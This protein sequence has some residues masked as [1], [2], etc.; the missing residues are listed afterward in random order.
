MPNEQ[1]ATLQ[2]ETQ[3]EDN[4]IIVVAHINEKILSL[5]DSVKAN[6]LLQNNKEVF[7]K[8][9]RT[10]EIYEG[11]L[12]RHQ[13][14]STNKR[15]NRGGIVIDRDSKNTTQDIASLTFK[16][17]K[18]IRQERRRFSPTKTS[19]VT[20]PGRTS[21]GVKNVLDINNPTEDDI[22]E[23]KLISV[24]EEIELF[25]SQGVRTFLFKDFLKEKEGLAKISYS[26][27]FKARTQFDDYLD[28]ITNKLKK[29]ILFL[30]GYYN[31]IAL[32]D[33]YDYKANK[34][35]D[36]FKIETLNSVGIKQKGKIIDT[37]H[38]TVKSSDF[39]SAAISFYNANILLHESDR[40]NFK[41]E[42]TI[43]ALLPT[44][45]TSPDSI[46]SVIR[47]FKDLQTIL[48]RT[49]YE[50]KKSSTN[51]YKKSS[52]SAR[53]NQANTYIVQ[54]KEVFN[55]EASRLGY[56]VF[57]NKQK[58]VVVFSQEQYKN[59]QGAEAVYG[60]GASEFL[61]PSGIHM[62]QEMIETNTNHKY[63]S[64]EKIDMFRMLKAQRAKV[65]KKREFPGPVA[66]FKIGS[67]VMSSFSLS[68]G[69]PVMS[70][71]E[72]TREGPVDPLEDAAQYVGESSLFIS[73]KGASIE[74][75]LK[76]PTVHLKKTNLEIISNIIPST[77]L[78][79]K[80]SV[81]SVSDLSISNKNSRYS[82]AKTNK[83][84]KLE[85]IPPQIQAL[86]SMSTSTDQPD[87]LR[88]RKT[89]GILQ[90][91]RMNVFI[92]K[93]LVGFEKGIDGFL[94]VNRP[95]IK[96]LTPSVLQEQVYVLAKAHHYEIP[97]IGI[98]K[99]KVPA[100]IYNN[101][102]YIRK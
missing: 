71:L 30:D 81:K 90:E 37:T 91:T 53:K 47:S 39:G 74:R 3:S 100:T 73:T 10:T 12:T 75:Q 76:K 32:S 61:T 26:L 1:V 17:K 62:G 66:E 35:K 56:N 93:A 29:S 45:I 19:D 82:R 96:P 7:N 84:F 99:D 34:F 5:R 52:V 83:K 70:A 57:S 27:V 43:K 59:R 41:Y 77:F 69:P 55:I 2:I 65:F 98:L 4:T 60:G 8:I 31:Y 85:K 49:Y 38:N 97:S 101:L 46:K 63:I 22:K 44:N 102:V 14:S 72:L 24:S 20:G 50:T 87:I 48:N 25:Q 58:G 94:D 40:F 78:K 23:S 13:I 89:S 11:K 15:T 42:K 6:V 36:S 88:N 9:N 67:S 21:T 33:S 18:A 28:H 80:E 54:A 68:V 79:D 86:T 64:F 16:N 95:I 92:I 51:V